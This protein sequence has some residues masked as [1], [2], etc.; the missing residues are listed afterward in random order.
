LRLSQFIESGLR[1]G[2][3]PKEV[4]DWLAREKDMLGEW[5]REFLLQLKTLSW[6]EVLSQRLERVSSGVYKIFLSLLFEMP[7]HQKQSAQNLKRFGEML[8]ELE[9]L[10]RETESSILVPRLQALGAGGLALVYVLLLPAL[11]PHYFPS[12]LDLGKP[13]YFIL[14]LSTYLLGLGLTLYFSYWPIRRQKRFCAQSVFVQ[15]LSYQLE[16]GSDFFRSWEEARRMADLDEKTGSAFLKPPHSKESMDEFLARIGQDTEQMWRDFICLIRWA[17]RSGQ[18][19]SQLLRDLGRD[20]SKEMIQKWKMES[21]ALSVLL[22]LPLGL[23][24]FPA[25]LFL[26]IGPQ[27]V[28]FG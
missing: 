12:F 6:Q 5:C 9:E 7:K 2:S 16:T 17:L 11:F 23:I 3:T 14:G 15:I 19:L 26:V 22:L 8:R 13:S 18:G 27:L 20:Q 1:A 24:C 10:K 4:L 25:T 21:K 28:R